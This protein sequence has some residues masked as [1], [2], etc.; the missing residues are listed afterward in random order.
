VELDVTE[1]GVPAST[2]EVEPEVIFMLEMLK[3]ENDAL[4]MDTTMVALEPPS[5]PLSGI[6][7]AEAAPGEEVDVKPF[8]EGGAAEAVAAEAATESS[9]ASTTGPPQ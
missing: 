8:A 5:F 9:P 3:V 6:G 4:E 7:A 1:E 2:K